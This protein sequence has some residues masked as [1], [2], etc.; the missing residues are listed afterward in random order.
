[1]AKSRAFRSPIRVGVTFFYKFELV[2][3]K[4]VSTFSGKFQIYIIFSASIYIKANLGSGLFIT[5]PPV[6]SGLSFQTGLP[7]F[8]L[9]AVTAK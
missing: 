6:I 9:T 7:P 1:V 2:K 8:S 5:V 4:Q 3:V